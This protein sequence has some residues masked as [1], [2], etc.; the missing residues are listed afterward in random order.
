MAK[1]QKKKRP[2]IETWWGVVRRMQVFKVPAGTRKDIQY[3]FH[4]GYHAALV[5]LAEDS[6]DPADLASTLRKL[7]ADAAEA[8]VDEEADFAARRGPIE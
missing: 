5:R 2:E 3:G 6:R 4:A 7:T 8:L 1:Q